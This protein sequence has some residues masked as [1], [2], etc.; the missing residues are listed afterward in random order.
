M[1]LIEDVTELLNK[2]K[3]YDIEVVSMNSEYFVDK[4]L[5]ATTLGDKHT[6]SLI[7]QLKKEL[8]FHKIQYMEEGDSWSVIDFGDTIVHLMTEDYRKIYKLEEFLISLNKK[9]SETS[10]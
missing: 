7:D 1:N 4:V 9:N 6:L 3:A 8:K 10:F 5:I 2:K